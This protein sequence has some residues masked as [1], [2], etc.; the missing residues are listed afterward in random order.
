MPVESKIPTAWPGRVRIIVLSWMFASDVAYD[1]WVVA[2]VV[3]PLQLS[4]MAPFSSFE[5]VVP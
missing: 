2:G 3:L 4:T 1:P 5:T